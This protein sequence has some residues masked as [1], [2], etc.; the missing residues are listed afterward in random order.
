MDLTP[1]Q[2]HFAQCVADGMNQSDAYRAAF[3][4]KPTTLAKTVNEAAS[5]MMANHK[6]RA[7]VQDLREK[8]EE[9]SIWRRLDSVKTLA[10][11]AKEEEELSKDR[12]AA[13][14]ELNAMHGWNAPQ[15]LTLSGDAE[16]PVHHVVL[17]AAD[18]K[19]ARA[20]M[21]KGDDV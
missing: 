12:I 15:K 20:E 8:L 14:K 5:R 4:I 2:E 17:T 7:R 19:A 18:Y 11:I 6:V 1:Q 13:I 21:M 9:A 3:D 16:N 10:T